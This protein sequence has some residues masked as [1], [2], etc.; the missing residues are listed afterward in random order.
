MGQMGLP[1][2]TINEDIIKE[3]QYKLMEERAKDMICEALESGGCITQD[4]GHDQEL[5]MAFM[6][7]K[8]NFGNIGLLHM[9]LVVVGTWIKFGKELNTKQFIQKPSMTG[10][11]NLSLMVILLRARKSGHMHHIPYFLSTMMTGEE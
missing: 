10:M 6:S 8:G 1:S 5:I 11:G 4:E 2:F 3:D 9:Y 7:T